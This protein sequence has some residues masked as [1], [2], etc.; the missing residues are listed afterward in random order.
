MIGQVE[1]YQ[2]MVQNPERVVEPVS[3]YETRKADLMQRLRK[4]E[5]QVRGLQKMIDDNRCSIDVLTQLA[6]VSQGVKK[7]SMLVS[8]CH[9]KGCV[10]EVLNKRDTGDMVDELVEVLFK[11]SR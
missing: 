9:V 2:G 10:T 5:G 7:V 1:R 8:E 3:L 4:I 11:F 6:A